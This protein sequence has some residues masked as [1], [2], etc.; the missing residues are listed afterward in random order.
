[1]TLKIFLYGLS[2][3]LLELSPLN[4]CS[5]QVSYNFELYSADI[6]IPDSKGNF[7]SRNGASCFRSLRPPQIT[8]AKS[9]LTAELNI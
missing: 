7:N 8:N 9:L 3:C 6:S 4:A 5:A 1:M 2:P